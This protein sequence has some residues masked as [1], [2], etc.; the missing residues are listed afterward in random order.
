MNFF[1]H[2]AFKIEFKH[3]ANA[4]ITK[5]IIR[6]TITNQNL[7]LF[8]LWDTGAT[9]SAITQKA[10]NNLDLKSK[11]KS[12]IQTADSPKKETNVYDIDLVLPNRV[13]VPNIR[14]SGV[15][16]IGGKNV[17][18]LIGMDIICIGDFAITNYGN[19]TLFSFSIPPHK[20]KIDFVERAEKLNAKKR[21]L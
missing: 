12:Y 10:V 5:V 19:K 7:D 18:L 9:S 2:L 20:N 6:N 4:L 11:F 21:K 1:P 17:N 8:A 13:L 14:V 16:V 15:S 3:I